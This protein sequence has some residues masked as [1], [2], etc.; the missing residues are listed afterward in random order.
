M[1]TIKLN[2]PG[3]TFHAL[4]LGPHKAPLLLWLH[5]FPDH[6]PTALPFLEHLTRSHRVIAPWLRGYTPSPLD[7]P[8]DLDTLAGDVLAMIEQLSPDAPI[9]L[10]GHDWGAAIT[11]ALCAV[12]PERVR[13]AVTMAVPHPLTLLRRLRSTSQMRRS[14]YMALF[15]IP[16]SERVVRANNLAMIDHL[17]RT[18]SPGFLL[19]AP[20]RT[21]LHA[22]L[23]AS[24]PAPISYYRAM[25]RPIVGFRARARRIAAPLATP[26]L[27]LHGA[28]DGCVLP[29]TLPLDDDRRFT[30]R[31][32]AIVPDVGHFLHLEAPDAI[33]GR[34]LTWLAP[35]ARGQTVGSADGS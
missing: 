18:W 15:Q 35:R 14:W 34:V 13:R 6:P 31:E 3:G 24:L 10:V 1:R 7:G 5:G 23:D 28:D 25:L 33:A 16:G 21:S 4:E 26:V 27:Q 2:L 29:P 19:D 17:W 32:L 11:Y 22:C 8:Y 12:A 9:D 20:R 30:Q